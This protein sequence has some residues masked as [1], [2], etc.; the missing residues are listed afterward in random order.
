MLD[1]AI[2]RFSYEDARYLYPRLKL[3]EGYIPTYIY[4]G[5]W[6]E[7]YVGYM[8]GSF[9]NIDTI[10]IQYSQLVPEF[11]GAKSVRI[12]REMF[13]NIHNDFK[14]ITMSVDNT[15]NDMIN[16]LCHAGFCPIGRKKFNNIVF[17]ELLKTD[18]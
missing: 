5:F 16:I 17:I 11:R 18:E 3:K 4:I 7:L 14:Y 10:N 8:A 13:K 2:Y 15:R 9:E 6:N 1:Y 12:V